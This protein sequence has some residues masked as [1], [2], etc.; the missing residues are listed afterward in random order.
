GT[1]PTSVSFPSSSRLSL[2]SRIYPRLSKHRAHLLRSQIGTS[3]PLHPCCSA[4]ASRH[5][6]RRPR[7]R[8][9]SRLRPPLRPH[10]TAYA[11]SSWPAS[12]VTGISSPT[13]STSDPPATTLM[14]CAR[15]SRAH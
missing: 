10:R 8:S 2:S 7:P 9:H 6:P 12:T 4:Y 14:C 13:A 1:E 11:S 5:G 3:R 15:C